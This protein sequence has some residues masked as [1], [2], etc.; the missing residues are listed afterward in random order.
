MR[1]IEDQNLL[2]KTISFKDKKGMR[3]KRKK[4]KKDLKKI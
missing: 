3:K 2:E 1:Q 4:K